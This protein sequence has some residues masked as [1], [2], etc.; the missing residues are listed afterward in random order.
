MREASFRITLE[1]YCH[2]WRVYVRDWSHYVRWG[3]YFADIL[4]LS[5][6]IGQAVRDA[7]TVREATRIINQHFI[8]H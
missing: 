7:P 8:I 6:D 5:G 1:H 2:L 3:Q 4:K